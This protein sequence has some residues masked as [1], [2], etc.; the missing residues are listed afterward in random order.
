MSISDLLVPNSFTVYGANFAG[1]G[2]VGPT[3]PQ[4][5]TGTTGP[6][7][8]SINGPTGPRGPRGAT[9]ATGTNGA[10][11]TTGPAGSGSDP[12]ISS[13]SPA[14]YTGNSTNIVNI[15]HSP[16]P[17]LG[18]VITATGQNAA[19]FQNA[20]ILGTSTLPVSTVIG[21]GL[22]NPIFAIVIQNDSSVFL[23]AKCSVRNAAS[24]DSAAYVALGCYTNISGTTTLTGTTTISVNNGSGLSIT[25][26]QWNT[27]IGPIL[28]LLAG[29]S[30]ETTWDVVVTYFFA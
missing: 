1:G 18:Q 5:P 10:T 15:S 23:E 8:P 26:P 4:G 11:G 24:T 20:S 22:V 19:T 6:T 17:V 2:P 30:S 13:V 25:A 27:P 7:G 3:G 14:L 12:G 21:A 9:G 29:G 28:Q 16:N